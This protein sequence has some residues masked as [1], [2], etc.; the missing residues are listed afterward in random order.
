MK[1]F[2][3]I[4]PNPFCYLG[5][6]AITTKEQTKLCEF[7]KAMQDSGGKP[8]DTLG[9]LTLVAEGISDENEPYAEYR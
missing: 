9:E 7:A 8:P 5:H 3:R 1:I 4:A 6:N 2:F